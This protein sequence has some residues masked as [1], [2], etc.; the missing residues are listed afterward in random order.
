MKTKREPSG[1]SS[2][3]QTLYN[4]AM[5]CDVSVIREESETLVDFADAVKEAI[6]ERITEL[7]SK[8]EQI[9]EL[10]VDEEEEGVS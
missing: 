6:A 3:E 4:I 5:D 10:D 7:N 9:D 8:I 1:E 2:V